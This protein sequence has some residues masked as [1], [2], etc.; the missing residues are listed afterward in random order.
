MNFCAF[1]AF[2]QDKL[3]ARTTAVIRARL[4]EVTPD[5]EIVLDLRI[6][7]GPD[8]PKALSVFRSEF[9]PA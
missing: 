9:M 3:S 4:I 5:K 1:P 7:G 2:W 8:D 6:G